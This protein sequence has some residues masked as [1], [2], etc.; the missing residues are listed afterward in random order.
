MQGRHW[1]RGRARRGRVRGK[2]IKDDGNSD[3]KE[4]REKGGLLHFL[5]TPFSALP[6]S[7]REMPT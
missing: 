2:D 7:P 3:D 1:E 4:E 6:L 5:A